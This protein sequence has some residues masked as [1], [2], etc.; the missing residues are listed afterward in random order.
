MMALLG[1][2]YAAL[3]ASPSFHDTLDRVVEQMLV[4]GRPVREAVDLLPFTGRHA[5]KRYSLIETM[6]RSED[7]DDRSVGYYAAFEC[8]SIIRTQLLDSLFR[9]RFDL[10]SQSSVLSVVVGHANKDSYDTVEFLRRCIRS[11]LPAEIRIEALHDLARHSATAARGDLYMIAQDATQPFWLRQ[12]AIHTFPA[13]HE[14]SRDLPWIC[15]LLDPKPDDADL[16]Q[17]AENTV[18]WP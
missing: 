8:F 1:V 3:L 12:A 10:Q 17:A 15:T 7:E 4:E 11:G 13:I 18:M 9:G 16:S 6:L 5:A 2:A 14:Y